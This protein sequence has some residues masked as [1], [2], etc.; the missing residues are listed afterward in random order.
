M[1]DTTSV[2]FYIGAHQDDWQLFM[3]P[4]AYYDLVTS[5]TRVIFIYTT[6]GE[7]GDI[8]WGQGRSAGAISS[9]QYAL[10]HP[11][12][13]VLPERREINGHPIATVPL[14]N[15]C[16]YYLNVP[17]GNGDGNGFASMGNISLRKLL[18]ESIPSIAAF[19]DQAEF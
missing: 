14:A 7:A 9:I 15:T 19:A 13:L 8:R 18:D 6:F 1:A 4:Q 16:S 11:I 3:S 2:A 5:G 10:H 12:V 17:D